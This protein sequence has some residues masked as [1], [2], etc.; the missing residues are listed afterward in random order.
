MSSIPR[1]SRC[2]SNRW[3]PLST[4]QKLKCPVHLGWH[5]PALNVSFVWLNYPDS[6]PFSELSRFH[7]NPPATASRVHLCRVAT[8]P[9]ISTNA[10]VR[11]AAPLFTTQDQILGGA[12]VIPVPLLFPPPRPAD[13]SLSAAVHLQKCH[14]LRWCRIAGGHKD[15][16]TSPLTIR[17]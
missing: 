17:R 10:T 16:Y 2:N 5:F 11:G 12:L 6:S 1:S 4:E 3:N 14:C 13:T 9:V 8:K 7:S 15:C